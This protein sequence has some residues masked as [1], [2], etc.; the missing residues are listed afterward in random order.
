MLTANIKE[1]KEFLD[2]KLAGVKPE[3]ALVVGSGL[4]GITK[5]IAKPLA[6]PYADI[7]HFPKA[8]VTA[9][10]RSLVL[11]VGDNRSRRGTIQSPL[12]FTGVQT[13]QKWHGFWHTARK[14]SDFSRDGGAA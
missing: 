1:T 11:G 10:P 5:E 3:I 9:R 7:P 6:I 14:P 12:N 13:G 4:G 2:S 8:T